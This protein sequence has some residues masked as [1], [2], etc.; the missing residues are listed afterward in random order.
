MDF[1]TTT[2]F[3]QISYYR[4]LGSG[5]ILICCLVWSQFYILTSGVGSLDLTGPWCLDQQSFIGK[6]KRTFWLTLFHQAFCGVDSRFSLS[7]PAWWDWFWVQ[8]FQ[9]DS[10]RI[11]WCTVWIQFSLFWQGVGSLFLTGLW[12][13]D[14]NRSGDPDWYNHL[15]QLDSH[16][17]C[18]GVDSRGSLTGPVWWKGHKLLQI[19]C[20]GVGSLF[21]TGLTFIFGQNTIEDII[22]SL[23]RSNAPWA[24]CGVDSR[25]NLTGPVPW[26]TAYKTAQGVDFPADC[27]NNFVAYSSFRVLYW[28]YTGWKTTVV[29][30]IDF[31]WRILITADLSA[32]WSSQHSFRGV[33]SLATTFSLAQQLC[34]WCF[35][36]ESG[37]LCGRFHFSRNL[38]QAA[39]IYMHARWPGKW[40]LAAMNLLFKSRWTA[41][42]GCLCVR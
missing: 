31:V 16:Q 9:L 37:T 28:A 25:H 4:W 30:P 7:G 3:G 10:F 20:D 6:Q 2:E 27:S 39:P 35:S 33:G 40:R 34:H 36:F 14:N 24:L 21:L 41:L 38:S 1:I 29:F 5:T 19:H 42:Q 13:W 18:C 12:L 26:C 11:N 22:D 15:W 23:T 32:T 17:T 8:Y